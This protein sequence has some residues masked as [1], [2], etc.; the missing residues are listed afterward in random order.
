[1]IDNQS[2]NLPKR[3]ERAA[4]ADVHYRHHEVA[5]QSKEKRETNP[6]HKKKN[7]EDDKQRSHR[8]TASSLTEEA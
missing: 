7:Q 3:V 6:E 8:I 1:M 2:E 5:D 4:A